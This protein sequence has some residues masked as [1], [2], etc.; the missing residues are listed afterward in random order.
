MWLCAGPVRSMFNSRA[1]R[2]LPIMSPTDLN[3]ELQQHISLQHAQRLRGSRQAYVM[4]IGASQ[5]KHHEVYRA[6]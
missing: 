1:L 2:F 3:H 6:Q 4:H 5:L